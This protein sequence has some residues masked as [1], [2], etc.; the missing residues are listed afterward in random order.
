MST[1]EP[2]LER[3]GWDAGHVKRRDNG[4]VLGN[5]FISKVTNYPAIIL[6]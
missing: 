4:Y 1:L 2:K 5:V 3:E 6:L